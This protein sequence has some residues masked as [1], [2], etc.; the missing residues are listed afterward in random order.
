MSTADR[1]SSSATG[2]SPPAEDAL[3]IASRLGRSL[4]DRGLVATTAESC[5]GGMIAA[6]LTAIPGS[7]ASF[8]R[9]F[10][11]YSNAA[12]MEMLGVGAATLE[13][14]GAVSE[15]TAQAMAAGALEHS[16]A[17]LAVAVTGVAGPDG[18]S[19]GKPVGTVCFAWARRDGPVE[20]ETRL[21]PGDR[22]AVRQATVIAALLGLE[23]RA[24]IG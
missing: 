18:G 5:T 10:V 9:G 17:Q 20:A 3:T 21:F 4:A 11:T 14:F 22:E 12:K 15:A 16:R 1:R 6:A 7:S 8:D 13:T 19:V 2:G 23:A 24:K